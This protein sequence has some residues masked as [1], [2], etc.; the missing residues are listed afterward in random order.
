MLRISNGN[1]VLFDESKIPIWSTNIVNSTTSDSVKAVLQNDGNFVLKDGS[2]SLK[3]LWH[4]FEHPTDTWLHGCKF[5]Y[6][7]IA[8]TSQRLI[9]WKNSEDPSPGLYSRELDTSDR[10]LKILWNRS[11][12]Y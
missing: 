1:L 7:N 6:N 8:K 3:I 2:N 10:A 11:K 4:K 5:G 9:S 12:N